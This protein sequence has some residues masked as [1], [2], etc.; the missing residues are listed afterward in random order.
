[1]VAGGGP[2]DETPAVDG[3]EPSVAPAGLPI[4]A[5]DDL[6]ASL[7]RR[8]VSARLFDT[9]RTW[10]RIGRFAVERPIGSGAMGMVFAARDEELD[11]PVAIKVLHPRLGESRGEQARL[12]GEAKLLAR[13]NHPNVVTVYEVGQ[14]DEQTFIAMELVQGQTL[15]AWLAQCERPWRDVLAV[16]LQAG[17]GLAA[18]H[19]S[20]LVHRD[21]KPDNVMIGESTDALPRARVMDFGLARPEAPIGETATTVPDGR[22]LDLGP[23]EWTRSG[24]LVGTPRY[25]APEQHRGMAA[26]ARSDQF[27]FCASLYEALAGEPA[28]VG[29]DIAELA[30]KKER[31]D[32]TPTTRD[33]PRW[34]MRCVVRGLAPEPDR[35]HADMR[36]L[37]RAL[38]DDPSSR[39]RRR[40]VLAGAVGIAAVLGSGAVALWQRDRCM[41]GPER[42]AGV[43]DD[44]TRPELAAP[45]ADAS[46][47]IGAD[48]AARLSPL[49]DAYADEWVAMYRESCETSTI[50]GEQSAETLDL[51]MACLERSR[52]RLGALVEEL[53]QRATPGAVARA[54]P[55]AHE[56]PVITECAQ[57]DR[58]RAPTSRPSDAD[59][60]RQYDEL[61]DRLAQAS[62]TVEL[63]RYADA[64][65]VAQESIAAAEQRGWT[66]LFGEATF[67]AGGAARGLGEYARAAESFEASYRAAVESGDDE[68]AFLAAVALG[69]TYSLRLA[70]FDTGDSWVRD[71]EAWWRRLGARPELEA[72]L[73]QV[74]AIA[75]DARGAEAGEAA[76]ALFETALDKA[77]DP[78]LRA[79][80]LGS[81]GDWQRERGD[82][83]AAEATLDEALELYLQMLGE[84]HPDVARVRTKLGVVYA[85]T[86]RAEEAYAAY[87]SAYDVILRALGE[88]HIDLARP[89]NNLATLDVKHGRPAD[90]LGRLHRVIELQERA[91]GPVHPELIGAC[92]NLGAVTNYLGLHDASAA[93]FRRGLSIVEATRGDDHE[94][95]VPLWINLAILEISRGRAQDAIA[96]ATRGLEIAEL[97]YPADHPRIFYALSALGRA[98]ALTGHYDVALPLLERAETMATDHMPPLDRAYMH[99]ALAWALTETRRD[100]V[101]AREVAVK[102]KH[103]FESAGNPTSFALAT[104]IERIDRTIKGPSD[105]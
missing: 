54:L 46:P 1:V 42:L 80:L 37:L 6:L 32:V 66:E 58:L 50:R 5:S 39:R 102:A 53:T 93:A 28:F 79:T 29:Q 60:R 7:V 20:G 16:F 56:L 43:W 59:G 22:M 62:I 49:L 100:L 8:Q 4:D 90:A 70:R 72:R 17:E 48:T 86:N 61:A 13:L 25:M 44:A 75:A 68:R 87:S 24:R 36:V 105:G 41:G 88:T 26:D 11:R 99:W 2:T 30:A 35:R 103:E 40:L 82:Y 91:F 57:I 47:A 67:V 34:L 23:Q 45:L 78:L 33:V 64:D 104:L 63:G 95:A 10:V 3:S 73:L 98:Q 55:A 31:A 81:L 9:P 83:V 76:G 101:R 96:P 94:T 92:A 19:A 89:L 21:F 15:R 84:E 77:T 12:R 97:R 69:S 74:R 65:S 85:D 27:A 52:R 14:V 38:A 18:A 71:A 51:R